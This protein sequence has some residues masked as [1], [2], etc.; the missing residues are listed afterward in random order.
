MLCQKGV[1]DTCCM[2]ASRPGRD[3]RYDQSQ[4]PPRPTDRGSHKLLFSGHSLL[5]R[6][7]KSE[8]GFE[9]E[10]VLQH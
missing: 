8:A 3:T 9:G 2:Q 6:C 7:L 5:L 4:V 10:C 1:A